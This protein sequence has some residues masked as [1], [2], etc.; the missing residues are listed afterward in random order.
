MA[1]QVEQK[2]FIGGQWVGGGEPIEVRNKYTGQTIATLPQVRRE[3][4]DA[5][6]AAASRAAQTMAEMPAYRRVEIL[7]RILSRLTGG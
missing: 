7:A 3:D 4:V 2:L 5:A 1:V 6:I